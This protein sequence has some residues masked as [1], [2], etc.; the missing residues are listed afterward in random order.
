MTGSFMARSNVVDMAFSGV[1]VSWEMEARKFVMKEFFSSRKQHLSYKDVS[2][3]I[4]IM[5]SSP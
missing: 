3:N 5:T 4:R 1:R 2:L